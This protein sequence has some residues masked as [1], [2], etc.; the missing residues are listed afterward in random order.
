MFVHDHEQVLVFTDTLATTMEGD[1][2]MFQ[3]KCW[4]IPQMKM[5]MAGTGLALVIDAWYQM[6]RVGVL[7]RDIKMLDLHA[8]TALRGIWKR[9][10]EDHPDAV[11]TATVYHFGLP[12]GQSDHVRFTYRSERNFESELSSEPGFG[13]KPVPSF[14]YE[15]PNSIGGFIDL[16]SKIRSEQDVEPKVSRIHIGGELVLTSLQGAMSRSSVIYRF[17]DYDE[18][19]QTMNDL[20]KK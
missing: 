19:W 10:H 13:V 5:V 9:L 14:V 11:G 8:P 6:L 20:Q 1:P 15:L 17:D 16:A 12:E 4:S 2:F 3:S 7:A 18:M